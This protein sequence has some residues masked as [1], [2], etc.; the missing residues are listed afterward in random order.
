VRLAASMSAV[1][2]GI[3]GGTWGPSG[4][5]TPTLRL[6]VWMYRSSSRAA[7]IPPNTADG[8]RASFWILA[9]G[10]CRGE[11]LGG[12]EGDA[13]DTP[14]RPRRPPGARTARQGAVAATDRH[15]GLLNE[16]VLKVS[17]ARQEPGR[18]GTLL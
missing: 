11:W 18:R 17:E 12:E 13:A 5:R 15:G 10:P 4:I 6:P 8:R 3:A 2:T 1:R 9:E 14:L 7:G 16:G